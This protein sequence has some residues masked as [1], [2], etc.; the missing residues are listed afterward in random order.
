AE[1][2]PRL[3]RDRLAL[4]WRPG[5]R[6]RARH[7]ILVVAGGQVGV[8]SGT[9]AQLFG[10]DA[11]RDRPAAHREQNHKPEPRGRKLRA[12]GCWSHA[13][14]ATLERARSPGRSVRMAKQENPHA[15]GKLG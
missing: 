12:L 4:G 9:V 8:G 14:E 3:D 7:G 11:A 5:G 13:A 6:S 2:G 1:L 15:A 10:I